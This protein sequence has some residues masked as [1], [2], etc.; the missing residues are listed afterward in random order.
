VSPKDSTKIYLVRHGATDW[1]EQGRWQCLD[2]RKLSEK[3]ELQAG[4]VAK[5]FARLHSE[6]AFSALYSSPLVRACQTAMFIQ[7]SIGLNMETEPLLREF[8]CGQLSGLKYEDARSAHA[9]FFSRLKDN[10]LDER[11]PGG[12]SHREYWMQTASPS[13]R[14]LHEIHKG[15]SVIAVTHAGFIRASLMMVM[16]TPTQGSLRGLAIDNCA[17]TVLEIDGT[18]EKGLLD[19]RAVQINVGCHLRLDLAED[20]GRY[21]A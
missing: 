1:N 12:E 18:D 4:S 9:E 15:M 2:D 21:K 8:D 17:Y 6:K 3:G 7:G 10:W 19:G 11:F 5:R 20:D 14:K 13:L 16:R